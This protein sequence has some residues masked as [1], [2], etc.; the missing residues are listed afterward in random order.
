MD[1]LPP[2]RQTRVHTGHLEGESMQR[3]SDLIRAFCAEGKLEVPFSDDVLDQL[4]FATRAN[5]LVDV[6]KRLWSNHGDK[7]NPYAHFTQYV[8]EV[9]AH[10]NSGNYIIFGQDDASFNLC[11][12]SDHLAYFGQTEKSPANLIKHYKD[13]AVLVEQEV[14]AGAIPAHGTRFLA[15][16]TDHPRSKEHC[17]CAWV[18]ASTN[19]DNIEW[20][21]PDSIFRIPY[22]V[23][24][25][26]INAR[27]PLT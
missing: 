15:V 1:A 26:M 12:V 18:D 6:P 8:N 4:R 3:M 25:S 14:Q 10:H 19:V 21:K 17:G 22:A 9:V 23:A 2:T 24:L 20:R 11:V 5:P 16:D 27:K 7:K 13:L